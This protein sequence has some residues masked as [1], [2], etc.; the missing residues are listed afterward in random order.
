ML[1]LTSAYFASAVVVFPG[2]GV[3]VRWSGSRQQRNSAK[4]VIAGGQLA[5]VVLNA[6]ECGL[7]NSGEPNP[8]HELRV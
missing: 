6:A 3:A 8:L 5:R 4:Y 2:A 7:Q 1:V